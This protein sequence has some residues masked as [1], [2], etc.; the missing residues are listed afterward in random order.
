MKIKIPVRLKITVWSK[1]FGL[2]I[3]GVLDSGIRLPDGFRTTT[4]RHTTTRHTTTT[5]TATDAP[6]EHTTTGKR[7]SQA[8]RGNLPIYIGLIANN[9]K[10]CKKV[11]EKFGNVGKP[12][13]LC[14]RN[15]KSKAI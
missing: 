4:T 5:S 13:Y 6:T 11:K 9:E 3:S 12:P 7:G 2:K 1:N 15:N 8:T 10:K 14:K